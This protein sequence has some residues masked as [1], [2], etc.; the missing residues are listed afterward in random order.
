MYTPTGESRD[1]AS[2]G[3][4]M[5]AFTA[6]LTS[7]CC[8]PDSGFYYGFVFPDDSA[9]VNHVFRD[10]LPLALA[11][12]AAAGDPTAALG[13]SGLRPAA[14]RVESLWPETG[15]SLAATTPPAVSPARR[16]AADQDVR[17][18]TRGPSLCDGP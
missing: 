8:T 18:N 4:G 5:F 13:P 17:R 10:N 1:W 2:R 7:G 12:I 14:P 11:V 15:I 3:L 16:T 6:E 9:L